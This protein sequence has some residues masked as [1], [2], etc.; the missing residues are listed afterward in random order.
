MR[1]K[2]GGCYEIPKTSRLYDYGRWLLIMMCH[3]AGC[4]EC[5]VF[6]AFEDGLDETILAIPEDDEDLKSVVAYSNQKH[7]TNLD[8]T[9][10]KFKAEYKYTVRAG[11][12]NAVLEHSEDI[13]SGKLEKDREIP[14]IR[15]LNFQGS[16][17]FRTQFAPGCFVD[18]K[19]TV[20]HENI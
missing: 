12:N 3:D 5:R 20:H 9:L 18:N 14:S 16:Q 19:Y 13:V 2:F 8:M 4:F 7:G 17:D 1:P 10:R 6:D 11:H 15:D